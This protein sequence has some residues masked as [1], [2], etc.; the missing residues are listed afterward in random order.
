VTPLAT[1]PDAV[2]ASPTRHRPW[3]SEWGPPIAVLSAVAYGSLRLYWVLGERPWL[4]PTGDD[5]LAFSGWGVVVLCG[6]A[7]AVAASS[8]W[9]APR[10][11]VLL[12]L[13][14]VGAVVMLGL[15]AACAVLLVDVVG[16]LLPGSGVLFHA[17][18]FLSR[19]G[20]LLVA[21]ALG[22][23][24][25]AA[26]RGGRDRCLAC[27]RDPDGTVPSAQ[28]PRAAF[29]AAYLVV[30]ACTVRVAAQIVADLAA[31]SSTLFHGS[32]V[33]GAVFAS[34][35]VLAGTLLPLALVHSWGRV[36]PGWVR[37]LAG[38]RVPRWLLL[39]PG[40]F[41]GVGMTVYFATSLTLLLSRPAGDDYPA[42]FYWV[43]MP[44]Y[45]VWGVGLCVVVASYW[46]STRPPCRICGLGHRG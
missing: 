17:G 25:L 8:M 46:V 30:L 1:A 26:H 45:F 33:A 15:L 11:R 4:P 16:L 18:A 7:A 39:A 12:G 13:V 5:L 2:D 23:T 24:V 41:L 44:A 14:A 21:M 10:G 29:V 40:G 38:R 34:G 43:T 42:A 31:G 3:W 32:P 36:W 35:A 28:P 6:A 22:A 20:A 9:L 27:G 19:L 37:P